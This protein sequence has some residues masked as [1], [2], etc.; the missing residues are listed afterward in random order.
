VNK[1]NKIIGLIFIV[2][3]VTTFIWAFSFPDIAK[4]WPQLFSIVMIILALGLIISSNKKSKEDAEEFVPDKSEYI[5]L[6]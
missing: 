6:N 3:S 4:F 1:T 5:S 2:F